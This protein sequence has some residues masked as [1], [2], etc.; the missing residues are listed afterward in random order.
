MMHWR[1]WDGVF[2]AY[3]HG[4]NILVSPGPIEFSHS[5]RTKRT[6][7]SRG[8][9]AKFE[10]E[11]LLDHYASAASSSLYIRVAQGALKDVQDFP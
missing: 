2:Q 10:H 6:F 1:F 9:I 5:L 8:M 4:N 7:S 3:K 11:E